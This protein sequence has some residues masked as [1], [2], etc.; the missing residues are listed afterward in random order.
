MIKKRPFL[1]ITHY[2]KQYVYTK[3]T[4]PVPRMSNRGAGEMTEL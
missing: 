4:F 3:C 1:G 2:Q